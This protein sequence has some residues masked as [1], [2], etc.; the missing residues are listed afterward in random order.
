[1]SAIREKKYYTF[2][3]LKELAYYTVEER[4]GE[5]D[6]VRKLYSL[7]E[8]LEFLEGKAGKRETPAEKAACLVSEL[9]KLGLEFYDLREKRVYSDNGLFLPNLTR[10]LTLGLITEEEVPYTDEE[11]AG[12]LQT[13]AL[14]FVERA[15]VVEERP[16]GDFESDFELLFPLVERPSLV[17]DSL[18]V[19]EIP[20]YD[21]VLSQFLLQQARL[22]GIREAERYQR[23]PINSSCGVF[24][25]TRFS[26]LALEDT[27]KGL[28]L[29][30]IS[31]PL[32]KGESSPLLYEVVQG[33]PLG[34]KVLNPF[35]A[36][37]GKYYCF[38]KERFEEGATVPELLENLRSE[39][40]RFYLAHPL[41][42][43]T[44]EPNEEEEY[45]P[46]IEF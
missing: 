46:E 12:E 13:S 23:L 29:W 39:F 38:F 16:V 25:E 42:R 40:E 9:S 6:L 2:P 5:P 4:N 19:K 15:D 8:F 24:I 31:P 28:S 32:L 14:F 35:K 22:M 30:K 26:L 7:E 18:P 43:E 37:G 34:F 3:D 27:R 36:L 10:A 21:E 41:R 44:F 17:R 1:V 20:F 45:G 11:K 33:I